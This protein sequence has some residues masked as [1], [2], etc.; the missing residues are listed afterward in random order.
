MFN[1]EKLEA[2]PLISGTAQGCP[3]SPLF[4]N[5]VLEILAAVIRKGNKKHTD[6]E[7]RNKSVHKWHDCSCRNL[8]ASAKKLPGINGRV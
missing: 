1:G 6:E 3:I 8:T 5:I 7:G 4:L 2:F